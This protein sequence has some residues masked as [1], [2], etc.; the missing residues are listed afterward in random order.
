[1]IVEE[2]RKIGNGSV[3]KGIREK[4]IELKALKTEQLGGIYPPFKRPG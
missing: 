2:A 1:L 3:S 4:F